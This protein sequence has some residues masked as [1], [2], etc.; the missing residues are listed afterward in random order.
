[1]LRF[2]PC[3]ASLLA[4]PSPPI[5]IIQWT[6]PVDGPLGRAGGAAPGRE[7][8]YLHHFCL[9]LEAFDADAVRAYLAGHG[10]SAGALATRYGAEGAGPSIY[11]E[12]PEGNA[13][14]L[15]GPPDAP[16]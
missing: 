9:R 3:V 7:G 11:L 15:K 14:E 12:D 1:M 5:S 2:A 8:R 10:C 6:V 16:A 13:V 4:R